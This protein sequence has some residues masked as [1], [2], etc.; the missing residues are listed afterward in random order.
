MFFVGRNIP[1][2]GVCLLLDLSKMF[3]WGQ[4][5]PNVFC[6]AGLFQMFFCGAG[7]FQM[8]VVCLLPDH[9]KCFWGNG[10]FQ[11]F[12]WRPDQSKCFVGPDHS[13]CLLF[14]CCRIIPNV[15]CG[16][17][18]FQMLLYQ[19]LKF[20]NALSSLLGCRIIFNV[21]SFCSD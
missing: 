10:S 5:I 18:S 20:R 6:L 7:T 15:F 19:I 14:A 21:L 2:V 13:K 17:G 1:N 4:L 12:L 8:F 11:M 9:S 16:A 3:L